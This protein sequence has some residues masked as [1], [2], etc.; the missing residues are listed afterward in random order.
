MPGRKS[1]PGPLHHAVVGPEPA[2]PGEVRRHRRMPVLG[3]DHGAAGGGPVLDE[4]PRSARRSPRRPGR[5]AIRRDR[6]SRAACRPRAARDR[7]WSAT[8]WLRGHRS[9]P[10][11]GPRQASGS[12]VVGSA[13]S[14]DGELQPLPGQALTS[15]RRQVRARLLERRQVGR[16]A[17]R[18]APPAPAARGRSRRSRAPGRPSGRRSPRSPCRTRLCRRS[19]DLRPP[20]ERLV[21][22]ALLDR[23]GR[24]PRPACRP[25]RRSARRTR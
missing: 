16:P 10:R 7:A 8:R 21:L 14:P 22:A 5:T 23:R 18:R 20:W 3:V 15:D 2:V 12:S 17:C 9:T 6:R 1:A 13:G 11:S 24:R 4:Q 19:A 25:C